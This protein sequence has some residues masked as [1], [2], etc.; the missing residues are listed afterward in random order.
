MRAAHGFVAQLNV[1]D[2]RPVAV[3]QHDA[4][5]HAP[6]DP[7]PCAIVACAMTALILDR[8]A[9][10]LGD[11]RIA[12]QGHDAQFPASHPVSPPSKPAF[13]AGL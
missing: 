6:P 9:M 13:L 8:P 7:R 3:R 11:D 10:I 4:H 5:S 12:P 1:A 2:D